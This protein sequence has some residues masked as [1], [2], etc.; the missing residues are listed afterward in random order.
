MLADKK[1]KPR[2]PA[3]NVDVAATDTSAFLPWRIIEFGTASGPL[4][5]SLFRFIEQFHRW[6][7]G[8]GLP[9]ER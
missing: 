4:A 5:R 9:V 6:P 8:L 3:L 2:P 7:I 1:I